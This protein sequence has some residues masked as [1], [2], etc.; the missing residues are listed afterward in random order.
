[1][2]FYGGEWGDGAISHITSRAPAPD[3]ER[4]EFKNR[5]AE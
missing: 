2:S 3:L 5:P 1:M 4:W